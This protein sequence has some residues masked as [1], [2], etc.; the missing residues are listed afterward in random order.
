MAEGESAQYSSTL[1]PAE[2]S[3]L[4]RLMNRGGKHRTQA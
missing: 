4:I 2:P 1:P 3:A